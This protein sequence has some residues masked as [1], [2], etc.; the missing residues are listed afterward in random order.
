M[1]KPKIGAVYAIRKAFEEEE[2]E[3]KKKDQDLERHLRK[4]AREDKKLR[5]GGKKTNEI[6]EVIIK[7]Q[8]LHFRCKDCNKNV[9][10]CSC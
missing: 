2:R 6:D 8:S 7:M 9:H 3:R 10:D 1:A 4:V 5:K